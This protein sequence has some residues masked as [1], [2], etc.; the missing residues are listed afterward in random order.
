MAALGLEGSSITYRGMVS[1]F[2][3]SGNLSEMYKVIE[4]MKKRNMNPNSLFV[5]QVINSLTDHMTI[6][7]VFAVRDQ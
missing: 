3:R 4:D 7:Q 1:G 2:A 5:E 6:D